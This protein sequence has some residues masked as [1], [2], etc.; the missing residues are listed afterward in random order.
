MKKLILLLSVIF[1]LSACEGDQGPMGPMGPKGNT[2]SDGKDG[3]NGKDGKDGEGGIGWYIK[4]FTVKKDE[5]TRVGRPGEL[6]SFYYADLKIP[7]LDSFVYADGTV[8]GYLLI[9]DDDGVEAKNG[10]PYVLH[11][12][13]DKKGESLWT[14]TYNFDYTP[15]VVRFYVT[16]S[17]FKTE[18]T[19]GTEKF[20]IVLMW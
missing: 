11:K 3:T 10:M 1:A 20:S 18:A 8:I 17:D 15:G 19:P 4:T 7:E 13:E 14:Q 16:Y 2:G 5:W 9:A 12:G 6:N